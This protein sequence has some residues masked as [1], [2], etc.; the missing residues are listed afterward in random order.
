[1]DFRPTKSDPNRTRLTV[2][3]NLLEYDGEL[4]TETTDI[5]SINMLLNSVI[6]T[7]GEIFLTLDIK[8]FYLGTP[9]E[10]HE[11]M[12]IK[13]DTIPDEIIK[14]YKLQTMVHNGFVYVEV[15]KGMYGLK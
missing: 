11:Y 4:Y 1:M 10:E 13:L 12:K 9:M 15:R 14:K 8:N 7:P 6:S 5:I 3:G 2:G